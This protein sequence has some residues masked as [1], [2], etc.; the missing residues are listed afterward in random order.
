MLAS[1]SHMLW[2][3]IWQRDKE[4]P[5]ELERQYIAE[6]VCG[7]LKVQMRKSD[8]WDLQ[9]P[10]VV[11]DFQFSKIALVLNERQ[12]YQCITTSDWAVGHAVRSKVSLSDNTDSRRVHW[13]QC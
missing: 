8:M 6:P 5:A 2:Y 4:A 12:W 10:K 3:Q 13:V 11:L 7:K 1:L 9:Q